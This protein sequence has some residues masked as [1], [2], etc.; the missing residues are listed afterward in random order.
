MDLEK[1]TTNKTYSYSLYIDSVFGWLYFFFILPFITRNVSYGHIIY[2]GVMHK[3]SIYIY[4]YVC[5]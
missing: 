4:V 2:V 1:N 3:F 5:V